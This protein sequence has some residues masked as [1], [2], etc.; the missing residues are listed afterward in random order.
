M[1]TQQ[2]VFLH[3]E[4]ALGARIAVAISMVRM[5]AISL[6]A[7]WLSGGILALRQRR[8]AAVVVNLLCAVP[9][10]TMSAIALLPVAFDRTAYVQQFGHPSLSNLPAAVIL[11]G[12]SLFAVAASAWSLRAKPW[13]FA[14]GWLAVLPI[15]AFT[16]YLAFWIRLRF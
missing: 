16:L 8:L 6:T 3:L 13:L 1:L 11:L 10:L 7:L 5:L 14:V 2:N 4:Y 12:T 15:V 9:V